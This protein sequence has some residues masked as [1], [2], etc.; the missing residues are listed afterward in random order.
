MKVL[1]VDDQPIYRAGITSIL[2]KTSRYRVHW[3]AESTEAAIKTIEKS[4]TLPS[5]IILDP[6]IGGEN[7]CLAHGRM[8]LLKLGLLNLYGDYMTAPVLVCS[9][10]EDLFRIHFVFEWGA[11]GFLPKKSTSAELIEA[12]DTIIDGKLYL[13]NEL[14]PV[15]NKKSHIYAKLS[16]RETDVI[17]LLKQNKTNKQIAKEMG[18]GIRTV[19]NYLSYIYYKTN[20]S[21]REELQ[22]I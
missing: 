14:H 12:I 18:I 17:L 6:M 10:L 15:L 2:E 22:N 1:L 7:G 19:E 9:A 21:N 11:A 20:C 5:I 3:Q 16:K 13:S 8:F 4:N